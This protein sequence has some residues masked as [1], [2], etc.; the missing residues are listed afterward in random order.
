MR[1]SHT[2]RRAQCTRS[3]VTQLTYISLYSNA[4]ALL[5][6]NGFMSSFSKFIHNYFDDFQLS[7]ILYDAHRVQYRARIAYCTLGFSFEYV[8]FGRTERGIEREREIEKKSM[9]TNI[10]IEWMNERKEW[11][12]KQ[13]RNK[14]FTSSNATIKSFRFCTKKFGC[15]NSRGKKTNERTDDRTTESV[16]VGVNKS[17]N[18]K[19]SE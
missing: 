18:R 3:S 17:N 10:Y 13:Q 16:G 14:A 7:S 15:E 12:E 11:K 2:L 19:T 9:H 1:A 6:Q 4:C 8:L 5:Y